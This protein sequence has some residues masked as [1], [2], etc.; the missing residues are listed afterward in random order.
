MSN[1]SCSFLRRGKRNER[2]ERGRW[3]LRDLSALETQKGKPK[4][5]KKGENQ[6]TFSLTTLPELGDRGHGAD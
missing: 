3:A 5:K 6:M 4:G 2:E 1:P